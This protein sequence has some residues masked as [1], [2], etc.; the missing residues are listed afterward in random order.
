[1]HREIHESELIPITPKRLALIVW[2][3]ENIDK[4]VSVLQASK[5]AHAL[6]YH[7]TYN[8][9]KDLTGAGYLRKTVSA[10]YQ[11]AN[12]SGLIHQIA[13]AEPFRQ[14]P[15]VCFYLGGSM[16]EKMHRLNSIGT[17]L[18]FTLFAAAEL[19]S[20][21]VRTNSVHAYVTLS[22]IDSLQ[23][24]LIELGGRRADRSEADTFLLP[25]SYEYIFTLS[26]KKNEFGI[27]PMGVLIADLESYGGLGQEQAGRIM[28]EW[29]SGIKS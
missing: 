6:D 1:M 20:P 2:L 15:A 17:D 16:T 8:A 23:G 24:K 11:V 10:R 21:Y 27:A 28:N 14:K 25:T 22:S 4:E 13:L 9:F 18:V 29:L 5:N 26:R 3:L 12:A 7:S 19:L